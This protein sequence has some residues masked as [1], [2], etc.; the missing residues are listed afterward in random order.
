MAFIPT[1]II[2]MIKDFD[3]SNVDEQSSR[4]VQRYAVDLMY[5]IVDILIGLKEV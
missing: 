5:E 4:D 2:K 1:E 3:R